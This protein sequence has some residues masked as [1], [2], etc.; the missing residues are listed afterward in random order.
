MMNTQNKSERQNK[1][2][3]VNVHIHKYVDEYSKANRGGR[4][5]QTYAISLLSDGGVLI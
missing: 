4:I 2:S 5:A 1:S 3:A